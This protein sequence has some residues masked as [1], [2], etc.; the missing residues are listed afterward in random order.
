MQSLVRRLTSDQIDAM[1]NEEITKDAKMRLVRAKYIKNTL[2]DLTGD[3]VFKLHS[4]SVLKLQ[5][6]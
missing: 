6:L 3:S 5:V 1:K 2:L 4:K